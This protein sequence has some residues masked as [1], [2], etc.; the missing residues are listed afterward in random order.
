MYTIIG[1][2]GNM[3]KKRVSLK[4]ILIQRI[5]QATKGT[6]WS[7]ADFLDLGTR[8]AIDKTL[9]RMTYNHELRRID[10]GLYD[11][12]QINSLTGKMTAPDYYKV[13]EAIARRDQIRVLIDGLTCANELGLTNAVLGKVIVHT[14]GRLRSIKL[15]NLTIKFKLTTPSKLYWAG[16]PGMRIIQALYWLHDSLKL[17][18]VEENEIIYNKLL[19]LMQNSTQG[20]KI[21]HDLRKGLHTVPTWMQKWIQ[22]LLTNYD[23]ITHIPRIQSLFSLIIPLP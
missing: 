13:I 10:R 20:H 8:E 12:P 2:G 6:V 15:G 21:C 16:R 9:Q 23:D 11:L 4:S 3:A 22:K 14:D 17:N 1:H 18:T 19:L 5:N 7:P